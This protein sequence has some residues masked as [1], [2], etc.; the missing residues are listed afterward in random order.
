MMLDVMF[1][2]EPKNIAVKPCRL[3]LV[4]NKYARDI[5]FHCSVP[6]LAQPIVQDRDFKSINHFD[7]ST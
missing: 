4:V 2:F 6:Q 7:V 3:F 1:D 5:D